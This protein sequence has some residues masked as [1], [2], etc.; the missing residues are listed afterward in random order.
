MGPADV[1]RGVRAQGC[2]V[3]RDERL[4]ALEDARSPLLMH[5]LSVTMGEADDV[6]DGERLFSTT[7]CRSEESEDD[8][9]SDSTAMLFGHGHV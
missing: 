2:L 8:D 1:E 4:S 3:W 9:D 6:D 7:A 5:G